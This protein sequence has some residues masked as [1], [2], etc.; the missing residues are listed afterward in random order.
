[1][2]C[3][4]PRLPVGSLKANRKVEHAPGKGDSMSKDTEANARSAWDTKPEWT[5]QS[6]PA[7]CGSRYLIECQGGK[8]LG[9]LVPK[10]RW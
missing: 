4:Q 10:E 2:A 7:Y 3:K 6:C 1:M 9:L 8:G 5:Y